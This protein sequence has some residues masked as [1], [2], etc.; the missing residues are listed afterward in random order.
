MSRFKLRSLT[1]RGAHPFGQVGCVALGV[2]HVGKG[3]TMG[4][5]EAQ[6]RLPCPQQ[7][8]P[9]HVPPLPQAAASVLH[10]VGRHVPSQYAPA[11]QVTP[12]PP[13]LNGSLAGFTH[14]SPQHRRPTPHP[15]SHAPPPG[16]PELPPLPPSPLPPT[17]LLP[18]PS[19]AP[20]LPELAIPE[21]PP[22]PDMLEPALPELLPAPAVPELTVPEPPAPKPP[23]PELPPERVPPES[24]LGPSAPTEASCADSEVNDTPPQSGAIRTRTKNP[25]GTN[26]IERTTHLTR[27]LWS[28]RSQSS[29]EKRSTL[30]TSL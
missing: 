11:P 13:Q 19:I 20:A 16:R 18:P 25:S 22:E 21:L 27:S 30:R 26:A 14:A 2:K 6:Q 24:P 12:H 3:P 7:E 17:P 29:R 4:P 8:F 23:L 9:Q 1:Q 28:G 5:D 15:A 10:G